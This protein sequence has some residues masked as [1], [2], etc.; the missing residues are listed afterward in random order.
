MNELLDARGSTWKPKR[1]RAVPGQPDKRRCN[2]YAQIKSR[3]E[4][5]IGWLAK[6]MPRI[7]CGYWTYVIVEPDRRRDPSNFTMGAIKLIEDALQR[8]KV[9][10]NDGW[11]QILGFRSYWF[12][13]DRPGV[14]VVVTSGD[15]L[16]HGEALEYMKGFQ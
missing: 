4:E 13:G 16:T 1:S 8:A 14:A 7:K 11:K 10:D 5:Q 9:L 12:V 3:A 6:P 15:V 2:Q